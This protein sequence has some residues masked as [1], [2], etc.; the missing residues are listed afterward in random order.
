MQQ[1]VIASNNEGKIREIRS[2]TPTIELLSLRDIGFTSEIPEPYD[3]FEENAHAKAAAIHAYCRKNVFA[4]DSGLCVNSL[5]GAPGVISAHYSGERDDEKN[6]LKVL[7]EL[8]GK[9]DRSAYYKAVI[10]LIWNENTHYFEGICEG[11]ITQEKR[12]NDGF[13]YDPIFLPDGQTQTFGELPLSVKNEISH[14]GKAMRK[15]I[16]FLENQNKQ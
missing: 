6:L 8:S 5:G 3:T 9:E 4:D 16:A 12:G 10:C 11:T 7:D 2:M 13:G 14:R 15:M 1:L